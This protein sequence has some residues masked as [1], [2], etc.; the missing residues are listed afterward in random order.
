MI[1]FETLHSMQKYN[2]NKDDFM[3][4]KL[5]MSK[6]TTRLNGAFLESLMRKMGFIVRWIKLLMV[7]MKTVSYSILVNG[8]PKKLI[9]PSH[10]IR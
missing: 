3:A 2:S 7:R 6:L 1:A 5:N 10:G 4:T 9:K 8:E